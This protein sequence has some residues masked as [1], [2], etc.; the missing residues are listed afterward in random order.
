LKKYKLNSL[1]DIE[2]IHEAF[3][4]SITDYFHHINSHDIPDW[5]EVKC[6]FE[7]INENTHSSKMPEWIG[8][9]RSCISTVATILSSLQM[10]L[11]NIGEEEL[12]NR[13]QLVFTTLSVSGQQR[14][15]N[16][17]AFDTLVVDE[18]GQAVEAETLIPIVKMN[19]KKC[20]L[21]GDIQQLP[22]TVISQEAGKL[23]FGRSMMERLIEHCNQPSSM[24]KIQYR[25]RPEISRW[26]SQK[27]YQS[28][29]END[30]SVSQPEYLLK[31]V[32]KDMPFLAPY[33]FI[34]IDG[35]EV[36]GPSNRSF[37][38][39][40]EVE[41]TALILHYLAQKCLIDVETRVA[42][43]S[44]YA[45]Q[46]EKMRSAL[47]T[48]YPKIKANT[49]DGFQGGESDIVIISCVR[50]NYEKQIGFLKASKRLNVALT[51]AKFSLIILGNQ[52]TLARSDIA[53]LV[54]DAEKRDVFFTQKVIHTLR[55]N[56]QILPKNLK[57]PP[58][59]NKQTLSADQKRVTKTSK[60]QSK[61]DQKTQVCFEFARSSSC[62]FGD[63]CKFQHNVTYSSSGKNKL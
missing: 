49:V 48:K 25:M 56:L 61:S 10:K 63:R 28:K 50:A 2:S 44:F 36:K 1:K 38:N 6:Y 33:S 18:A 52:P 5:K 3:K 20:L 14:F 51:R 32:G 21:I 47:T 59:K 27:Y 41:S 60:P 22:A 57:K 46:V 53:E 58:K 4:Q 8:A 11:S 16:I 35:K 42:I 19:P 12:L 54:T 37:F 13:S 31:E 45:L 34:D 15:K 39:A 17:Q 40:A 26:P 7:K 29:L 30:F 55:Q 62:R 23:K 43:I 24:L 9:M